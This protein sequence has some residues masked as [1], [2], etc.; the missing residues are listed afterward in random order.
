MILGQLNKNKIIAMLGMLL[1]LYMIIIALP[2]LIA[3]VYLLY[4]AR[5]S[6]Q[7]EL[8]YELVNLD[9]LV[10]STEYVK[11]SLQ[12][13][14]N[15]SAWSALSLAKSQQLHLL[16]SSFHE[17]IYQDI[18]QSNTQALALSPIE[19]F[20]WY[21]L[22]FT[23]QKLQATPEK[24]INNLRLSCYAGRVEPELVL[25]RVKMFNQYQDLLNEEMLDIL[26]T[27]IRLSSLLEPRGLAQL[28]K[29]QTS[30][31]PFVQQ[32]LQYNV[33]PLN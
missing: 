20:A 11:K 1:C 15:S 28:V 25:K 7:F 3:A 9:H 26:A 31:L 33:N 13:F 17:Q 4:P 16:E 21:R 32:A 10:K 8:K 6:E 27:Q 29:Q 12:W 19:P 14:E 23:E 18:Y 2:R 30:L 5:V 22:F 24:I